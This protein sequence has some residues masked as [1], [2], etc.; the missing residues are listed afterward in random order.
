M[1]ELDRKPLPCPVCGDTMEFQQKEGVSIDVC[2][3]HGIWLDAGEIDAIVGKI[4]R[5]MPSMPRGWRAGLAKP[6]AARAEVSLRCGRGGR[7]SRDAGTSLPRWQSFLSGTAT[8]SITPG[9]DSL[10]P[11]DRSRSAHR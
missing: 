10:A 3:E 9:V 2:L 7:S 8:S 11:G 6:S 1:S 5:G 4:P